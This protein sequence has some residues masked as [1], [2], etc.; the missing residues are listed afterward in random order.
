MYWVMKVKK[1]ILKLALLSVSLSLC[2]CN[3][4]VEETSTLNNDTEKESLTNMS[5]LES[6]TISVD[7][8]L[9]EEDFLE[10]ADF[11]VVFSFFINV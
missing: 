11:S 1:S 9:I 4:S 5:E 6:V 3:S 7:D 10:L 8:N 2:S